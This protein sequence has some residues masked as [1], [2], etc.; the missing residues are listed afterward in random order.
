MDFLNNPKVK[1]IIFTINNSG[2]LQPLLTYPPNPKN[3]SVYFIKKEEEAAT[4]ENISKL[5]IFGDM[6]PNPVEELSVLIEE[7]KINEN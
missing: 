4:V 2:L 3:K 1:T 6:A 5:C 7:V